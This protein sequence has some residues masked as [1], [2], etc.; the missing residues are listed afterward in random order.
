MFAIEIKNLGKKYKIAH[1]KGGYLTL[2]DS[3]IN[4]FQ[5]PFRIFKRR[6]KKE[7]FWA[8][9]NINI[10][11]APGEILGVIGSNGAGKSTL[12]KILSQITPPST[13]EIKINGR[14][15]SLL[16]VGTGFH[17]ELSGRE[18]ISLNGAILGMSRQEIAAKFDKIVE[19]SGV[20]KFLDTPVKYYS[21]GMYVRLAFAVAAHMEP[22]ILIVDEVL[23]VGDAEFQKKCLGKMEEVARTEGRTVIFV[24]HNMGAIQNL[25]QKTVWLHHGEL[26]MFGPT[27]EVIGSYLKESL[28]LADLSLKDRTDRSGNGDLKITDCYFETAEGY[29]TDYIAVG[30]DYKLVFDYEVKEG[31]TLSNIIIGAGILDQYHNSIFLCHNQMTGTDFGE[32][33]G[34]GKFKC[35]IKKIPLTPGTYTVA[36]RVSASDVELD[37]ISNIIKFDVLSGDFFG[38]G[39]NI[40]HSLVYVDQA[41]EGIKQ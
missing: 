24:S 5:H 41:W 9:K 31:M 11:V 18:N 38:T 29:R 30:K 10:N 2:R 13:G 27:S 37:Y 36:V 32:I 26:K 4:F 14:V 33:S 17:P 21:S 28:K 39:S 34:R 16:E 3:L 35:L 23:A 8:L 6:D 22:D 12:L 40:I 25:C 20:D 19:F 1:R 7:E 15:G